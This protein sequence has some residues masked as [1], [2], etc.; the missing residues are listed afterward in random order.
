MSDET[1]AEGGADAATKGN[2]EDATVPP[3][4]VNAQYIKDLSFE[5][6]NTPAVFT[7]M[8]QA[9]PDITVNVDVQARPL[10]APVYEVLLNVRADCKSG[11]TQAF[12]VELS[13]GGVFT[14]NVPQADVHP[15][16]LIECPRLLFP[17]ARQIVSMTT[18]NGGFLPLML[19]PIDFASLYQRQLHDAEIARAPAPPAGA[20][21]A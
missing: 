2:G 14:L 10:E 20:S 12:L 1:S 15:V 6:P 21:S 4:I 17:F 7:Q 9:Q 8:Q 19:G 18:I 11:E 5:A 13:Y 16:L 3:L